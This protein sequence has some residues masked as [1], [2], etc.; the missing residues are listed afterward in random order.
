MKERTASSQLFIRGRHFVDETGRVVILKGINLAGVSVP[1]KPNGATHIK[2]NWPPIDLN[3]VSWVGR[4]FPLEECEEHF[5]RLSAWGFNCIRMLAS[6]EAVEH[7]G[8]YQYDEEYLDYF[9]ELVKRAGD[10]GFY[11]FVNFHQ[12]VWSRATGGDGH[13][14]WL[15]D[16]V[17]LDYT[18]FDEADAAITM[19]YLW[20]SVPNKNK[21]GTQVWFTNT[22]LFPVRTMWTLFWGGKDFAPYIKIQDESSKNLYSTSEYMQNHY[23]KALEQIADR[24][25]GFSHIF[26]FNPI[27]EP[28][29]GYIGVSSVSKRLL[30][31]DKNR[32]DENPLPGIAWSP[33][34]TM[35][36]AAGHTVEIEELGIKPLTIYKAL[37]PINT[38]TVNPK[39][40]RLWKKGAQDFWLLHGVWEEQ[41]GKPTSK[42]DNYFKIIN[43]RTVDFTADYL[44]P[45]HKRV[46]D[47]LKAYNKNWCTIIE[48]DPEICGGIRYHEWPSNMPSNSVDGFHWYD[49]V[50]LSLKRFFKH[51][52][53]DVARLRPA[54]GLKGIQNMYVRQMS[55]HLDLSKR[56]NDGNCPCLVGEFGIAM[57]M[58][59]KKAYKNWR[60]KGYDAFKL[61]DTVLDL[62]YNAMDSLLFSSTLWNYTPFNNNEFG[63]LWNLEDLSIYS[64]DQIKGASQDLY[65]GARGIGG[66]CRPY[67]VKIAG[68]PVAMRF[69]RK[70]GEFYL[71]FEASENKGSITEI[72]VP[73]YQYPKGC[74]IECIGAVARAAPESQRVFVQSPREKTVKVVI[75]RA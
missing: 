9:T 10:F 31:Y 43:E 2:E 6:W 21:Y 13:P 58:N 12:D 74:V 47:T 5:K 36:A 66:F 1:F 28:S 18:K 37:H 33:L 19:Q 8:P 14:L 40:I 23:I 41:N 16:K 67:A 35:A 53:F 42:K 73:K 63:D 38:I 57:D 52:S 11:V 54:F 22:R 39:K 51:V 26:G 62:M 34:D 3:N 27:N 25:K 68:N 72:F 60:T 29:A 20:D 46:E 4:P 15:F 70:N 65:S 59:K 71:E 30:K 50:Q 49:M 69:D 45:F 24:V 61:H 64:K 48:N 44:I 56:V 17:G 32:G 55:P 7:A 75:N